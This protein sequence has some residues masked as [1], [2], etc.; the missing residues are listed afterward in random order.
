MKK[1][2]NYVKNLF[3]RISILEIKLFIVLIM[4]LGYSIIL[5]RC[6]SSRFEK[7]VLKLE[8]KIDLLSNKKDSIKTIIIT[9]D[10]KILK[11]EKHY[12]EL[13]NNIL[14]ASDSDNY[15]WIEQYIK[16]YRKSK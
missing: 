15:I 14:N 10:D 12:K 7:Q 3:Q 1:L 2:L 6:N 11:N 16:E 5:T 4:L 8:S 9:L 13:S